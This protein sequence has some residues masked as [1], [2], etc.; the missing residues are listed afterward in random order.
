MSSR[1][2]LPSPLADAPCIMNLILLRILSDRSLITNTIQLATVVATRVCHAS[3]ETTAIIMASLSTV[4]MSLD[5]A[6]VAALG[7][8][9]TRSNPPA[10]APAA[11]T[12]PAQEFRP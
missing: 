5:A 11:A 8:A 1:C 2:P 3:V 4:L 12:P 10:A 6:I 7:N 9:Q